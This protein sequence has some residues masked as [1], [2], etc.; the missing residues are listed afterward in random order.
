MVRQNGRLRFFE[1]IEIAGMLIRLKHKDT[2]LAFLP[3][4]MAGL[5]P[6]IHVFEITFAF[7][8]GCPAQGRA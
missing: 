6:A 5:V 8:R 7:I 1:G 3:S 2:I 4:V